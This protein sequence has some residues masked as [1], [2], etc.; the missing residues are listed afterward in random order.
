[1]KLGGEIMKMI[2]KILRGYVIKNIKGFLIMILSIAVSTTIIFGTT[3]ARVSQSKY[4]SDEV[5]RQSPS[6]QVGAFDLKKSDF[7]KL[8]KDTNVKNYVSMKYYGI[9]NNNGKEYRVEEF[10]NISFKKLKHTL[11]SGRFPDG[12]NEI[13]VSDVLFKDLESKGKLTPIKDSDGSNNYKVNLNYSKE[14]VDDL[15]ER[16]IFN[17]AHEFK[18]IGIYK[19]TDI[20][21]KFSVG[22]YTSNKLE[23]PKEITTY[24]GLVDLKTGFKDVTDQ[25]SK[26]AA[27]TDT[28]LKNI[29]ANSELSL[30]QEDNR[31]ASSSFDLFDKGTIIASICIIFNVFNIMM[32]KFIKEIGLLR[33]VGMS[34]KQSL[35][36]FISKNLLVLILG[37]IIGFTGGYL[38]ADIM[39]SNMHLS[40][41]LLDVS[42]ASIYISKATV[43]K[44]LRVIISIVLISTIVPIII[45]LKS[46]PIDM[47][48]GKVNSRALG[49]LLNKI[50]LYR[51]I[52][53]LIINLLNKVRSKLKNKKMNLNI[54]MNAKLAINN[55]KRNLLYILTTAIIAGMAGLYGVNQFIYENKE[56]DDIGSS[57]VQ[58]MADYD[59]ELNYTGYNRSNEVGISQNDLEKLADIKGVTDIY[60]YNRTDASIKQNVNDF[61]ESFKTA[62]SLKSED[63]EKDMDFEFIGLNKEALAHLN[64]EYKDIIESGRIYEKN[65]EVIEAV[66][67]NNFSFNR[68]QGKFNEKLKLGDIVECKVLIDNNSKLEYKTIK[69]KIVGFL[70]KQWVTRNGATNIATPDIL[71]D[72]SEYKKITGNNNYSKI[73]LKCEKSKLEVIKTA[74]KD[75]VRNRPNIEY[76]D[77]V[78]IEEDSGVFRWQA[79]LRDASNSIMLIITA[80]INITFS[81]IAS[82]LMR[83]REFGVM[84]SVGLSIKDLKKILIYEG[85]VYGIISSFTG[86]LFILISG[87]KWTHL[88]RTISKLQGIP[89]TGPLVVFP[90]LPTIV[91]VL[92]TIA[93]SLMS[94]VFTFKNLTKD[95]IV[96]QLKED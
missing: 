86:I 13:I 93:V 69:I 30:A 10:N 56:T 78:T 46:Y 26:L 68:N 85:L 67:D 24:N 82:I 23:Y 31:V 60:T 55:S 15:G 63:K 45:T 33:V 52:K 2:L 65:D 44:T 81:I 48:S 57:I 80:S 29:Y 91:F 27:N 14:Y 8:V 76:K 74:V 39:I 4:V 79:I 28:G 95:S 35:L 34:K 1:M 36:F 94:T 84:R 54:N 42:K 88:M 7:D 51:K 64:N 19:T 43:I 96:N 73:K 75:I 37:L 9:Y 90:V 3:A 77:R 25:M 83:K 66:V 20:M 40:S 50:K 89:Y 92:I 21:K 11:I 38:L 6:Y 47:M 16:K 61:S 72:S 41:T 70:S 58:S 17:Q 18:I 49:D 12:K 22:I 59:I 53:L 87:A 62:L 5:Y 32:K 71:V